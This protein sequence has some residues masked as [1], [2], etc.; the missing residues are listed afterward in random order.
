MAGAGSKVAGMQAISPPRFDRDL[1]Q[2]V[3]G[4]LLGAVLVAVGLTLAL[5]VIETPLVSRLVPTRAA[6][7]GQIGIAM[8]VWALAL[9]AGGAM[10]VAGT[11]R[12]AY[13]I[14]SV[15]TRPPG[16]S[17]LMR[18]LGHLPEVVV[19]GGAVLE[20]GR[21]IPELVIGAFGVAVVHA[22]AT[23][24]RVRRVGTTWEAKTRDGWIPTE[25]PLDRVA[26]EAER[27]RHWLIGG[28][29]DFVVRVYAALVTTDA[30]ISRSPSCAVITQDQI[31]AWLAA[32]PRQRTLSAG[33]R[34][35]L[36][37]RVRGTA[38]RETLRQGW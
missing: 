29:L 35:H 16:N 19:A 11:N 27:V 24:D 37:A 21:P 13:A 32:L 25:D 23:N 1:G 14:A 3:G 18:V 31:P 2:L 8:L 38:V 5:L 9:I 10:S 22:V 30:T 26:R 12:L 28:D 7:S 15:R 4:T 34:H 6:G 17:P 20:D 36:L 33:R